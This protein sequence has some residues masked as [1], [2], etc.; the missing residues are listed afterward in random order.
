MTTAQN[1]QARALQLVHDFMTGSFTIADE[2]PKARELISLLRA[3]ITPDDVVNVLVSGE[4]E[5][6]EEGL[7][8]LQI[9]RKPF[10]YCKIH[11][12]LLVA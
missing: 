8:A 11:G 1:N 5:T 7:E 3:D 9:F 2:K 4:S 10:T 6:A 12:I